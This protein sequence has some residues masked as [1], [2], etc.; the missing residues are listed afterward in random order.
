[1]RH[2]RWRRQSKDNNKDKK[3]MI[4]KQNTASE[5]AVCKKKELLCCWC[6]AIIEALF[7]RINENVTSQ[8]G[9]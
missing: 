6:L 2:T 1:M 9:C 8:R 5:E 4:N 3:R 7:I